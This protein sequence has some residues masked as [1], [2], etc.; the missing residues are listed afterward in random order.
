MLSRHHVARKV[1]CVLPLSHHS[2]ASLSSC[3]SGVRLVLLSPDIPFFSASWS[4]LSDRYSACCK[5][6]CASL[7][8][9]PWMPWD[10]ASDFWKHLGVIRS[11]VFAGMHDTDTNTH[12]FLWVS[13]FLFSE[14][15]CSSLCNTPVS[16]DVLW[17][18]LYAAHF[19]YLFHCRAL[20]HRM[21]RAGAS[22][23][24]QLGQTLAVPGV[25]LACG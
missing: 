16:T 20:A 2:S 23:M 3:S 24:L 11:K 17:L 15:L 10:I 6:R 18:D 5:I 1:E 12:S 7:G 4:L 13:P 14:V 25:S 8:C 19:L 9:S 21:V 22:S